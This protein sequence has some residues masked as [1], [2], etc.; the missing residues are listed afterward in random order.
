M[1][2]KDMLINPAIGKIG[3]IDNDQGYGKTPSYAAFASMGGLLGDAPKNQVAI[4][5]TNTVFDVKHLIRQSFN[6]E[7]E[8]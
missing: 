5:P 7:T 3:S 4:N 8:H 1:S 2:Y 6:R